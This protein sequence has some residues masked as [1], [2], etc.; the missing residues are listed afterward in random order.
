MPQIEVSY[1]KKVVSKGMLGVYGVY[2]VY[3]RRFELWRR[4]FVNDRKKLI[5]TLHNLRR[6][7]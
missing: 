6:K 5:N 3:L 4:K 1:M 2:A 7:A